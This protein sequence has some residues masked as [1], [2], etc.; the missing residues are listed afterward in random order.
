MRASDLLGRV[1]YESGE[2][3]G[4]IVDLVAHPDDSGNLFVDGAMVTPGRRG[5]LLGYERPALSG[6]GLLR[7]LGDRL[8][9]GIHETS[10]NDLRLTPDPHQP[11][12]ARAI[13]G[14]DTGGGP[15]EPGERS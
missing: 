7:R 12:I 6:P 2:P 4:R 14:T 8:H 1:A 13:A 9:R 15:T 5:R 3:A 10:L 11:A